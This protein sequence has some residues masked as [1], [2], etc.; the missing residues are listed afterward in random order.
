MGPNGDPWEAYKLRNTNVSFTAQLYAKARTAESAKV[1]EAVGKKVSATAGLSAEVMGAVSLGLTTEMSNLPCGP[2]RSGNPD[3][4]PGSGITAAGCY[5]RRSPPSNRAHRWSS[6]PPGLCTL[7]R[8]P[9]DPGRCRTRLPLGPRPTCYQCQPRVS[10]LLGTPATGLQ[11]VPTLYLLAGAVRQARQRSQTQRYPASAWQRPFLRRLGQRTRLF[12][13]PPLRSWNQES[14]T[15]NSTDQKSSV[16]LLH[17]GWLEYDGCLNENIAHLEAHGKPMEAYNDMRTIEST[18]EEKRKVD[19]ELKNFHTGTFYK[20]GVGDSL[21]GMKYDWQDFASMTDIKNRK[22][23]G[24]ALDPTPDRTG[25]FSRITGQLSGHSLEDTRHWG[26]LATAA[27][28]KQTEVNQFQKNARQIYAGHTE[29]DANDPLLGTMRFVFGEQEFLAMEHEQR[30]RLNLDGH[31]LKQL[32]PPE[33]H[34]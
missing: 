5:P 31:L 32:R 1:S 3:S 9:C 11:G 7:C 33:R 10:V 6:A 16:P 12:K 29:T 24:R 22:L 34:G 21:H 2:S 14:S 27:A 4:S 17:M 8:T 30:T 25:S 15:S 23:P 26:P 20:D 18:L 13:T 28:N 19:T